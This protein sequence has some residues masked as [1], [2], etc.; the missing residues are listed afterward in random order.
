MGNDKKCDVDQQ[1]KRQKIL[2]AHLKQQLE[3]LENYAY[4]SGE[5]DL[6]SAEVIARQVYFV[7]AQFVQF[8]GCIFHFISPYSAVPPVI[9]SFYC[10]SNTIR[11]IFV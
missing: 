7:F 9:H 10:V 2:I 4:E 1:K 6:P 8:T 5:G 11:I 3:D